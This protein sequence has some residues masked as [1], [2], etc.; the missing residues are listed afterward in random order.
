MIKNLIFDFGKVLVDYDFE[1]FFKS[2]IPN[3]ERC[4]A[5]TSILYNEK[6]QQILDREDKP[7]DELMEEII[8]NNKEYEPEIRY[9]MAHYPDVV[10]GEMEGM[11]D[12][13]K[14]L[15]SEGYKFYGLTNWCN[16]VHQTMAQYEI[17]Q[18]LD[19][20]IISSEEKVIKPEPE[21]YHRLFNK[22]NL[23][24]EE[25]IF[26]D[27]RVE[28]IVGGRNVGM[29]GIIFVD[30]VQYEKELRQLISKYQNS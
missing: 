29:D 23:K 4:Q 28:N 3:A 24:P 7:F 26:A 20:Y 10:K 5:V 17:F 16:K 13:L 2:Y 15:K 18:L 8:G 30:A 9:F 11:S 27:D 19:G 21:I 1:S 25:C 12:L 22:Y 6:V 14:Q